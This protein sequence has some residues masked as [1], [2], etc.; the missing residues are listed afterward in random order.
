V[1]SIAEPEEGQLSLS[2]DPARIKQFPASTASRRLSGRPYMPSN[3]S[4]RLSLVSMQ[5]TEE[6]SS[7]EATN[8]PHIHAEEKHHQHHHERLLSQVAEWL[9]AEKA[10]RAARKSHKRSARQKENDHAKEGLDESLTSRARSSSQDSNS[11]A[12]SLEQLQR[13]L[14]DNMS[15]FGN[16]KL[17]TSSPSKPKRPSLVP[18][19]T[20]P[21]LAPRKYSHSG[22]R[23]RSSIKKLAMS[24]FQS[25]DTEFGQDG[26][27][28]VNSCDA[29]L[30]N[31]KT[32]SYGGGNA[33][34]STETPTVR[35]SKKE[36][37]EQK[38]WLSFKTE[39][40]KITHTLQLKHWRKV[41]FPPASISQDPSRPYKLP[42][43][44]LLRVYGPQVE[45]L[46]DRENELGILRRLARKNI[47]PKLLGTF[48]NGR[49]EQY[50]ESTTLTAEDMRVESTSKQIA[51]RMRELHDGVDLLDREVS[52][53]PFVW[54]NWDKW[55]GRCEE[56]ITYLDSKTTSSDQAIRETWG[57]RGL[58]CGVEWP[59]FKAAV[60]KYRKWLEKY[61]GPGGVNKKLVFAHND[62]RTSPSSI[63]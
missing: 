54:R 31:S 38:A 19:A 53:G 2:E 59:L 3:S 26:D 37:K 23:R 18:G 57:E 63:H 32:M 25:S 16:S 11:S 22:P 12:I 45:H 6:P 47:G 52:E 60:D 43:K 21:S 49:F 33:E 40:L 1:V 50:F 8:T 51:K 5:S 20:S 46:I 58:V 41:V 17:P 13:I 34:S 56:V 4:S 35:S 28:V 62:V 44:L 15:L 36:E 10:K 24:G 27:G 30:D 48:Q 29:V 55:V 14:E 61:Y 42:A 39:I 9:Q 7:T